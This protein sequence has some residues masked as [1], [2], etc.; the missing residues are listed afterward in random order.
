MSG[1][2]RVLYRR[3]RGEEE[4]E[5]AQIELTEVRLDSEDVVADDMS[6]SDGEMLPGAKEDRKSLI[7]EPEIDENGVVRDYEVVLKHLGFGVFHWLLMV[8]NG[9]ALMSDAVEVLSVSFILP[10]LREKEEFGVTDSQNALLS[11]V[12]F[13]GML[14]GSYCWG[15]FADVVGRRTVLLLSLTLNGAF[16]FFSAFSTNIWMF[17]V[18]RFVSGLG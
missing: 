14:F 16:G 9:V 5:E 4:D 18:F 8:V 1:T 12:I 3:G 10:L 17:I 7:K 11:S 6:G 2:Y 13:I 15:G